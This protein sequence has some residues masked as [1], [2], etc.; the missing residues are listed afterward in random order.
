MRKPIFFDS[1]GW[2]AVVDRKD[3][4]HE[5]AK[6]FYQE[7]VKGGGDSHNYGLCFG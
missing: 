5:T 2:I 7:Y 1:W 4:Y 6:A 3:P